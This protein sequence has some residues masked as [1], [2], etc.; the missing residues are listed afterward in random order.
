MLGAGHQ[1]LENH[2]RTGLRKP[3]DSYIGLAS[4]LGKQLL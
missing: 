3:N 2:F 1:G 4:F